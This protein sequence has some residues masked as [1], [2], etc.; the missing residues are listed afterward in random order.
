MYQHVET[1]YDGSLVNKDNRIAYAPTIVDEIKLHGK[2]F[3]KDAEKEDGSI[4]IKID[5]K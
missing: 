2:W 4:K 5:S 1:I 3:L